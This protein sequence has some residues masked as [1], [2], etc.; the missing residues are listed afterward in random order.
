MYAK[1]DANQLV[2]GKPKMIPDCAKA[3]VD[4]IY[5]GMEE[6]DQ[7]VSANFYE[8]V[9]GTE[10]DLPNE[11]KATASKFLKQLDAGKLDW[12]EAA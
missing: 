7:E 5:T 9:F 11:Y 2:D 8:L 10:L 6:S 4:A 12:D 1:F 3:F